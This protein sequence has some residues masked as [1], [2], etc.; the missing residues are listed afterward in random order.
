MK[1]CDRLLLVKSTQYAVRALPENL[2]GSR[3]R[4]HL[5]VDGAGNVSHCYRAVQL[6]CISDFAPASPI[7]AYPGLDDGDSV[8][9]R[10]GCSKSK[11]T[12]VACGTAIEN[13]V[14]ASA[15]SL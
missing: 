7:V 12:S 9:S 8:M 10:V 4:C 13:R 6:G 1:P 5:V 15:R 3:A 11:F 14:S 2:G